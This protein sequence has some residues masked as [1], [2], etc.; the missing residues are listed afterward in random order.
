MW[1]QIRHPSAIEAQSFI[2]RGTHN[3]VGVIP[4]NSGLF[5]P[6]ES[7]L[8][9]GANAR[10]LTPTKGMKRPRS[11][12]PR[13]CQTP[14]A[15]TISRYLKHVRRLIDRRGYAIQIVLP[16]PGRPGW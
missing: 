7:A 9:P 10:H 11:D 5:A 14:D 4:A 3:S 1:G 6:E 2:G 16:H 8:R 13:R 15:R 12:R